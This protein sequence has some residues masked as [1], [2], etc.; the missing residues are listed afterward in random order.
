ML[1]KNYIAFGFDLSYFCHMAHFQLFS[2]LIVWGSTTANEPKIPNG[3]TKLIA[4]TYV[5]NEIFINISI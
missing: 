3:E 1:S 5:N 4:G 2:C